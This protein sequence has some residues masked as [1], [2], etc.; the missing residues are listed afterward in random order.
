M[1]IGFLLL[2]PSVAHGVIIFQPD[3][4][5]ASSEF[6]SSFDVGNAIDG[7]GLPVEFTIDDA[8]ADYAVN[9]H[10]TTASNPSFPVSAI[11]G[12]N[13]PVTIGQFFLWNHRS[14]IIA[15]D[16]FYEVIQFDLILRDSGGN[17][18]LTLNDLTATGDTAFAQVYD[19][20]LT[21]GV[22]SVEF[23]I[24]ANQGSSFTGVA[25]F[26]FTSIPEPSSALLLLA[27]S[28]LMAIAYRKRNLPP[29][30]P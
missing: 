12:F 20:P 13:T 15:N 29:P 30:I 25:E 10:W 16:A 27:S 4:A 8:H 23:L 3:T 7:S 9:N 21:S 18:L 1:T 28:G 5:T 11:L 6:S 19:L 2:L 17:D 14:N 22:S 24:D 26:A